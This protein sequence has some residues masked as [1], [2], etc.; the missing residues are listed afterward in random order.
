MISKLCISLVLL[1]TAFALPMPLRSEKAET[2]IDV[3]DEEAI[4]VLMMS[5]AEVWN[6][7]DASEMSML[8]A[9]DAD[10]TNWS[11]TQRAQGRE[12][13]KS[14]YVPLFA[15]NFKN[16]RLSISGLKIRQLGPAAASVH[17][18]WE[19]DG[20]IDRDGKAAPSR[21]YIPLF[22]L[23]R[24][25]GKWEIVVGHMLLVQPPAPKEK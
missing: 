20:L 19:L 3:K 14:L 10:F 18:D 4:R 15:G 9:E 24:N 7:H 21:K 13:I 17:G 16:T 2:G 5:M 22:V 6:R 25:N 1:A 23:A 12:A 11:G 8:Y